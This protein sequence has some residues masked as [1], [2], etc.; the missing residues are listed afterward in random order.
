MVKWKTTIDKVSTYATITLFLS[1]FLEI[2][3]PIFKPVTVISSCLIYIAILLKNRIMRGSLDKILCILCTASLSWVLMREFTDSPYVNILGMIIIYS[4]LSWS[5]YSAM[6]KINRFVAVT[7]SIAVICATLN[8]YIDSTI[9]GYAIIGLQIFIILKFI[10]PILE[11]LGQEH[12]AKRL[13]AEA[14]AMATD[15][16]ES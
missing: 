8:I 9:F 5:Y 7:G 6:G 13:A 16:K 2:F 1:I 15:A 10:D 11:K 14:K 3:F 4:F 12:R